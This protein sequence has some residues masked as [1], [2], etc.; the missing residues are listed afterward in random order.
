MIVT[1]GPSVV[2]REIRE[3]VDVI[4]AQA[5]MGINIGKDLTAGF[6]NIVGGRSKAYEGEIA[7][8]VTEVLEELKATA[9]RLGADAVVAVDIDYESVGTAGMLM[10]AASGTAVRLG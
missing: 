5:I 1:T 9:E 4:S 3:Y 10:V 6:R 2:G 7:Q 8:A